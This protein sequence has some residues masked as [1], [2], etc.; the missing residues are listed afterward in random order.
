MQ[1]KALIVFLILFVLQTVIYTHESVPDCPDQTDK[2]PKLTRFRHYSK[3]GSSS[4]STQKVLTVALGKGAKDYKFPD[5][6]FKPVDQRFMQ[7]I[8]LANL[9]QINPV[10]FY[11]YTL[12]D[13]TFISSV[14]IN[15]RLFY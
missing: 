10:N 11:S 1:F 3:T 8:N 7:S 15:G 4:D 12:Y 6:D 13:I 9:I 14:L 5:Q 2:A